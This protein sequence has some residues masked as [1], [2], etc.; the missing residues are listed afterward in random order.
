M[1]MIPVRRVL[2]MKFGDDDDDDD[3]EDCDALSPEAALELLDLGVMPTVGSSGI[4]SGQ[5]FD[6]AF[7][8]GGSSDEDEYSSAEEE[9][10]TQG[11]TGE[12]S[13]DVGSA[14]R[15]KIA[16]LNSS[17]PL[18]AKGLQ[19]AKV[20]HE[21]GTPLATQ[22]SELYAAEPDEFDLVLER[23]KRARP[24]PAVQQHAFTARPAGG[25]ATSS[26]SFAFQA[27]RR[28]A[29]TADSGNLDDA[30]RPATSANASLRL[31]GFS[32]GVGVQD[33][34]SILTCGD[35]S[36]AGNPIGAARQKRQLKADGIG[37][38]E[39]VVHHEEAMEIRELLRR[40]TTY[41]QQSCL[42]SGELRSRKL[43]VDARRPETPD[44]RIR[45]TPDL[46]PGTSS[47]QPTGS[48]AN[49]F[50]R[51]GSSGGRPGSGSS[52]GRPGS[53]NVLGGSDKLG[54]KGAG[55]NGGATRGGGY[56][57]GDLPP[58]LPPPRSN[59]DLPVNHFPLPTIKTQAG[60]A[61]ILDE[62]QELIVSDLLE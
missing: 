62:G 30:Y 35:T 10:P 34:A 18:L 29:R 4:R 52:S 50:G 37:V 59:S 20:A 56:T 45:A 6:D 16:P 40:Y 8:A 12:L 3:Y 46:R 51:P 39:P 15:V 11:A 42:S 61:L 9:A 33:A 22:R 44:V 13:S 38:D 32:G 14:S 41:T 53:S 21:S 25:A 23:L 31:D 27:D 5:A 17:H 58:R 48:S 1:K 28:K 54:A 26:S 24:R 47:G 19:E 57:V 43:D 36:L 49:W 2:R 55:I 60:E 7:A